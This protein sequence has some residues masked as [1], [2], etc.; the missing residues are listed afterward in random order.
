M[1]HCAGRRLKN[2]FSC[3]S[4]IDVFLIYGY[5][6]RPRSPYGSFSQRQVEIEALIVKYYV[7]NDIRDT[8]LI[9][10]VAAGPCGR[11]TNIKC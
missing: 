2:K 11:Y 5:L 1:S 6:S 9:A 4:G 7:M 10:S 8:F 3:E